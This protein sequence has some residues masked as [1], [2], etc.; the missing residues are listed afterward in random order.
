MVVEFS[1]IKC[2]ISAFFS[3]LYLSL[4]GGK[5]KLS[6]GWADHSQTV[7][8]ERCI[9]IVHD[10]GVWCW[11]IYTQMLVAMDIQCTLCNN[12]DIICS[13]DYWSGGGVCH[14][15]VLSQHCRQ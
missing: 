6:G 9:S 15:D 7:W 10:K 8:A 14:G 11:S 5:S 1:Y 3:L 2:S 4:S 12:E 13:C